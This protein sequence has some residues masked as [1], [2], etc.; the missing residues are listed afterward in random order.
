MIKIVFALYMY[1]VLQG[2]N[3]SDTDGNLFLI[4]IQ[5]DPRR[6]QFLMYFLVIFQSPQIENMD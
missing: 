6:L 4:N 1:V 3:L 2:N 5:F